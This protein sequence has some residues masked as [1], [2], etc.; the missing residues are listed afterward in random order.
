MPEPIPEQPTQPAEPEQHSTGYIYASPYMPLIQT[1]DVSVNTSADAAE[2]SEA[3]ANT[4]TAAQRAIVENIPELMRAARARTAQDQTNVERRRAARRDRSVDE[5]EAFATARERS[6][7]AAAD[8]AVESRW[9]HWNRQAREH[10]EISGASEAELTRRL[11]L[12]AALRFILTASAPQR[13][14]TSRRTYASNSAI[15]AGTLVAV[16]D[17][18][19]GFDMFDLWLHDG[20]GYAQC[21]VG[22]CGGH[23]SALSAR[24]AV[25][26]YLKRQE[27]AF[28]LGD[29]VALNS[30]D[31]DYFARRNMERADAPS[32]LL[33]VAVHIA[34]YALMRPDDFSTEQLN[35]LV[36]AYP[37]LVA[38]ARSHDYNMPQPAASAFSS[39]IAW[40]IRV[41][42]DLNGMHVDADAEP[43]DP[44]QHVL[45]WEEL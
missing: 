18:S 35:A 40:A 25:Y 30:V 22:S 28:P 13:A 5:Q 6:R 37:R 44:A 29:R 15:P 20:A 16:R 11:R 14:R 19:N 9:N 24:S 43:T 21:V 23:S 36:Q 26:D 34:R 3:V 10:A 4:L 7:A 27:G 8:Q 31:L 17:R 12:G 2:T 1:P 33:A 38:R 39:Y 42:G 32:V 41:L 45:P